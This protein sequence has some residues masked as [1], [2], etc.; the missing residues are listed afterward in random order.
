MG[1]SLQGPGH[2]ACPT[3]PGWA[4][5]YRLGNLREI[6]AGRECKWVAGTG[7]THARSLESLQRA[8]SHMHA[9]WPE[10]LL[11]L[12]NFEAESTEV[13]ESTEARCMRCA[14][15][16]QRHPSIVYQNQIRNLAVASWSNVHIST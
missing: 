2:Q 7:Q 14:L 9:A 13:H 16:L 8:R 5:S 10:T 6:L 1:L 11:N 4:A 12:L 3:G 15:G